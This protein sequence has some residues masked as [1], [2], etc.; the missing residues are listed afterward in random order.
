MRDVEATAVDQ[1][2]FTGERPGWGEGFEYDYGRHIAAYRFATT[3]AA[4]QRVL[5]A[6][7]GEGFG[8]QTLCDVAAEVT[9]VDYS[10]S[11]ISECRRLWKK[12]NLRF[13][14]VDLTH[15]GG[16][17]ETFDLVINFQV[18]EHIRDPEPF[19][20]G[21]RERLGQRGVLV[22]TT[23]NR[24]RTISE[25]PYHVREYTAVELGELLR[26][27]FGSVEIRGMH[28]NA[29]VEAFEAG[30]ARAVRNILRLDPLGIRK[31]LPAWLVQ[32]AFARL[33]KLV[34]RSAQPSGAATIAPEDFSVSADD[35][36][37]A[38]DLVALCRR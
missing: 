7:C 30:R 16:F 13:E 17:G 33:A 28:G 32:F 9:G 38:L 36:D 37:R 35:V 24:L 26:K 34:R 29:G 31:L 27:V 18:L 3:L 15:P 5:D 1:K 4:G 25:N 6:G 11:A 10:D 20:T 2:K 21:L 23:P 12:P 8:T 14:R 19:L 22:L